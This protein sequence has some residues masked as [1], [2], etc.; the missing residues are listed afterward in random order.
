MAQQLRAALAWR[1]IT[2]HLGPDPLLV[3]AQQR[4]KH[5]QRVREGKVDTIL[6]K[7]KKNGR[8]SQ[9]QGRGADAGATAP[10]ASGAAA[11]RKRSRSSRRSA[12]CATGG[13]AQARTP[14]NRP[15]RRRKSREGNDRIERSEARGIGGT[16]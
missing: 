7:G 4:T 13:T 8:T 14:G 15:K 3:A 11:G 1:R 10:A 9:G 2:K 6:T 12:A 5:A 16:G